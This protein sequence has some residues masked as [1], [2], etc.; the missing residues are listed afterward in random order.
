MLE[1]DGLDHRRRRGGADFAKPQSPLP[2][3]TTAV[4]SETAPVTE[5]YIPLVRPTQSVATMTTDFLEAH[6]RKAQFAAIVVIDKQH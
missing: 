4:L 6:S 5:E 2:Y 3:P 1:A